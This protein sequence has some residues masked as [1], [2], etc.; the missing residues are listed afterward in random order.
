MKIKIAFIFYLVVLS[1][2]AYDLSYN[3]FYYD[4]NDDIQSVTLVG[5]ENKNIKTAII[6]NEITVNGLSFFVT[7]IGS[8]SFYNCSYLNYI[9]FPETIKTI[10]ERAF[11]NCHSLISLN[12]PN[13]VTTIGKEAFFFT[14]I[15]SLTIGNSVADIEERAFPTSTLESIIVDESNSHY[16]SINQC[17]AIIENET[18]KLVCGCINTTIPDF[19]EI[20]GENAFQYCDITSLSIPSSVRQIGGYA[21]YGCAKLN[22]LSIPESVTF[23]GNYAFYGC[24]KLTNLNISEGVT[25]IGNYAFY[26]CDFESIVLPNSLINIGDYAF[27][28]NPFSS[29]KTVSFGNNVKR[30]GKG[31]FS[32]TNIENI[33]IPNSVKC[34]DERAFSEC[35]YLTS[36]SLGNE[37]DSIGDYAFYNCYNLPILTIP[38]SIKCIGMNAFA[39]CKGLIIVNWNAVSCN[40]FTHSPFNLFEDDRYKD[41]SIII[42]SIIFGED[43]Q[44]IPSNI[45]SYLKGLLNV[46]IGDNVKTIGTS[47]FFECNK[48]PT[49]SI[50]NSTISI[51]GGSFKNCS[52]LTNLELGKNLKIIGP[53]AFS[54]CKKLAN[55]NIPSTN[56]LTSIENYAFQGCIL[57][58]DINLNGGSVTNIGNSAFE[59]CTSL[60]NLNLGNYITTI[61]NNAF[62]G[63]LNINELIFPDVIKTIG[64]AAFENCSFLKSLIIPNSMSEI[65]AN[66]FKGCSNLETIVVGEGI[67]SM[68]EN[69]FQGCNSLKKVTWNVISCNDFNNS[70]F[71]Q[72]GINSF[73]FG[74]KVKKIPSYLLR[75]AL[76][77]CKFI[78]TPNSTTSIGAYSFCTSIDTLII[79][80]DELN[81]NMCAFYSCNIPT[82]IWNVQNYQCFGNSA[83]NQT[84]LLSN[85]NIN[86][87]IC[88]DTAE[89]TPSCKD[90]KKIQYIKTSNAATGIGD[91]HFG[92]CSN[93]TSLFI[94]ENISKVGYAA[95][96]GCSRLDTVFWNATNC[97][98]FGVDSQSHQHPAFVGNPNSA[99]NNN[100]LTTIIFGS[101]VNKIPNWL[102]KNLP[103]L[104]SIIIPY[105]VSTIGPSSFY[106]CETITS[107][108]SYIINPSTVTVVYGNIDSFSYVNKDICTLYVPEGSL[109]IYKTTYP[110]YLF[111]NIIEFDTSG[112]DNVTVDSKNNLEDN[113]MTIYTIDGR[114]VNT[115]DTSTLPNGIY[116]INGKKYLIKH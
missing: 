80:S 26:N 41:K 107:I 40:D 77:N 79:N 52:E 65:G 109:E 18:N 38:K 93:L 106:G 35:Q 82:F 4:I 112:I 95:F 56:N 92:N 57:I 78:K 58:H 22:N 24:E 87:L 8:N 96:A 76:N 81:V 7:D 27:S 50:P 114:Y 36:I 69:T 11:V 91:W 48:L 21:F 33:T 98:D 31:A 15:K 72:C 51:G 63:C 66:A 113:I 104:T 116:I 45:C 10:C 110:W 67:T 39:L 19:V 64:G 85:S 42:K 34:I 23:I 97:E 16:N 89:S 17:N 55:I 54:N 101:N 9:E 6:P 99:E 12:I 103:N 44:H 43:V 68:G 83:Y 74:N 37:L 49:I 2:N 60:T 25:S 13:S 1:V 28:G 62:Q 70:P 84:S 94:G 53:Y 90:N 46:S 73:V 32:H 105:A 108:Y 59:G 5:V 14:A 100:S 29:L 115:K 71:F 61:G 30:I 102:C 75:G 47:A 3:G 86:K 20:I 111:K 88:A